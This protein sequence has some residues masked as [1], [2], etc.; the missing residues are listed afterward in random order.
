MP[1]NGKSTEL[2]GHHEEM[3]FR[4]SSDWPASAFRQ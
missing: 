2:S 4:N 3:D 1:G